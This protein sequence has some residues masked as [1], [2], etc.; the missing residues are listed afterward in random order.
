M[1][2]ITGI[3]VGLVAALALQ[4][5]GVAAAAAADWRNGG[6]PD[7]KEVPVSLTEG[8]ERPLHPVSCSFYA[9]EPYRYPSQDKLEA[10][11][12]IKNCDPNDPSTCR[13][14]TDIH[15]Y[16]NFDKQWEVY[17]NGLVR[18]GPPCQGLNSRAVTYNCEASTRGY[19]YRTRTYMTTVEDGY[20]YA[21]AKTSATRQY[22]C[23]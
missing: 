23:L 5:S 10:N 20:T 8:E 14:E 12:G 19:N 18:Y 9:G 16:N 15:I 22:Y 13:I 21:D 1:M 11:G 6:H 4:G 3:L 2:K 7:R 17:V